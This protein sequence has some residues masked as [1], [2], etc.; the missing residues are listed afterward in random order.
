MDIAEECTLLTGLAAQIRRRKAKRSYRSG[1][2]R[3]LI[4]ISQGTSQ[5]PDGRMEQP[6]EILL[7]GEGG[8]GT[9]NGGMEGPLFAMLSR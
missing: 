3:V 5:V 7:A 6:E 2:G 9:R 1:R 8:D 4:R